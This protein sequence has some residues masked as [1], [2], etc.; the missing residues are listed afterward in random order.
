[1]PR[2]IHV[3]SCF[4]NFL[5]SI[6]SDLFAKH[7]IQAPEKTK[8]ADQTARTWRLICTFVVCIFLHD[9]A[10]LLDT[11]ILVPYFLLAAG[12]LQHEAIVELFQHYFFISM[13]G[14]HKVALCS[15]HLI[16]RIHLLCLKK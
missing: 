9:M 14:L 16:Y 10:H 5:G 6:L 3:Y 13:T 15:L 2:F 12:I 1:M 7:T 4:I 11:F 8:G